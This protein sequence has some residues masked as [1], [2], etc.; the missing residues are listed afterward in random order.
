MYL[1][2]AE[3]GRNVLEFLPGS[4]EWQTST[5]HPMHYQAPD[6][7]I[8][9]DAGGGVRTCEGLTRVEKCVAQFAGRSAKMQEG[10]AY[11]TVQSHVLFLSEFQE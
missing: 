9:A 7:H 3:I 5:I 4:L 6:G 11:E 8:R 2:E 1:D 10:R